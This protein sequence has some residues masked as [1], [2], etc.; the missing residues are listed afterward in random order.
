MP[1]P[2]RR[3]RTG[4]AGINFTAHVIGFDVGDADQEQLACIAENT[5]GRFFAARDA[6]GLQAALNEATEA[7]TEEVPEPEVT[8]SA[9]ESAVAGS[10]VEV[11]WQGEKIQPR[12]L[13]T[14]VP[15][16]ADSDAYG[17]YKRVGDSRA[18]VLQAPGEPGSYEARYVAS[19][20]GHAVATTAVELTE[21]RVEVTA[22]DSAIAGSRIEV[23]WTNT[24]H[25]RDMV[26]IVP[27]DAAGDAYGD[28]MRAGNATSGKLDT[29]RTG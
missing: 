28:Y 23:S 27:A 20:T 29:D 18:A 14:I 22:P 8:I 15:Q 2:V 21:P 4:E 25:H 26:T 12:D 1:I 19:A 9:P 11:S 6:A 17:D 13:V 10:N 16:D 5:G 3:L 24:I 7:A